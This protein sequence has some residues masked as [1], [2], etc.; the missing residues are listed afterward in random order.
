MRGTTCA[1]FGFG[2]LV[3][4]S[5]VA[6]TAQDWNNDRKLAKARQ[7]PLHYGAGAMPP[8]AAGP[9]VAIRGQRTC[10]RRCDRPTRACSWPRTSL[11]AFFA[12]SVLLTSVW[13]KF[14]NPSVNRCRQ[15]PRTRLPPAEIRNPQVFSSTYRCRRSNVPN[16][17]L[18]G[19]IPWLDHPQGHAANQKDLP[20][21]P[22]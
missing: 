11:G 10:G 19:E 20:D 16:A 13:N 8:V 14:N 21:R 17:T 9:R 3:V 4:A 22:K 7:V 12:R 18:S 5:M 1:N 2:A 6:P 15:A